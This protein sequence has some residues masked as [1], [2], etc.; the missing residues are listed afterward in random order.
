MKA[1]RKYE[2]INNIYNAIL[3]SKIDKKKEWLT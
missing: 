1:K 3:L 2:Y